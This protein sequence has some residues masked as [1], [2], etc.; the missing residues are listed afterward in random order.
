MPI[1]MDASTWHIEALAGRGQTHH[2]KWTSA[3]FV[4]IVGAERPF[5]SGMAWSPMFSAGAIGG[6]REL[7]RDDKTVWFAG[8]G[9]RLHVWR[10]FFASFEVGAVNTK[11]PIFSSTYQFATSLGWQW[12]HLVLSVRHLSNAG[13]EGRNYGETMFL[14]G[15][16]F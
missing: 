6:S 14:A 10:G 13:L 3:G 8:A 4:D 2:D 15:V 7:G 11:T 1:S 12:E 16:A 9:A 5:V